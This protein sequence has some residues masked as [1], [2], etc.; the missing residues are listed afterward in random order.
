MTIKGRVKRFAKIGGEMVSLT[1]VEQL[2]NALW[3]DYQH[4]VISV[5]D[6]KKGEQLVLV[7]TNEQ[8]LREELVSFAKAN[9]VGEIAIPK[10][11]ISLKELPLLATGKVDYVAVKEIVI[12]RL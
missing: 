10:K 8:P 3:P 2:I 6:P 12:S 11:I 5:P 7:T 9:R 1:M 4:A